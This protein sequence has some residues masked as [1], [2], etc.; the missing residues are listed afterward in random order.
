MAKERRKPEKRVWCAKS[1]DFFLLHPRRSKKIR[2]ASDCFCKNRG[3]WVKKWVWGR[4][5]SV[6]NLF[7][8]FILSEQRKTTKEIL[9]FFLV[10]SQKHMALLSCGASSVH[11]H[12]GSIQ[13]NNRFIYRSVLW[14]AGLNNAQAFLCFPPFHCLAFF[15]PSFPSLTLILMSPS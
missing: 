12:L 3:W 10:A 15:P 9:A 8:H 14:Q 1:N 6:S 5:R 11:L 7:K 13:N 4:L 2:L